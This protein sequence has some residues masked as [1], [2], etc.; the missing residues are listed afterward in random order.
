MGEGVLLWPLVKGS[1]DMILMNLFHL[2]ELINVLSPILQSKCW[3]VRIYTSIPSQV[4]SHKFFSGGEGR[5]A[6]DLRRFIFARRVQGQFFAPLYCAALNLWSQKF[7]KRVRTGSDYL[8]TPY[9]DPRMHQ[10][11]PKVSGRGLR[12][13]NN[14]CTGHIQ[15]GEN[16]SQRFIPP[17]IIILS[18]MHAKW[19]IY[20]R[21]CTFKHLYI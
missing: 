19:R 3:N 5:R 13:S 21:Y 8:T 17:T 9:L 7:S 2:P 11:V 1:R 18:Y 15:G 12:D 4:R 20:Y 6:R 14:Q 16:P 10:V